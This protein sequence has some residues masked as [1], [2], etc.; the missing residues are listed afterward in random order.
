MEHTNTALW[1]F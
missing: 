1:C